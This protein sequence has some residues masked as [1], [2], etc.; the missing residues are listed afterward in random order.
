[1]YE[2]KR[3]KFITFEGCDGS[4]KS[5]QIEYF[6][7]YLTKRNIP[8]ITTREPGGGKISEAIR[9]II[10]DGKNAEMT[11]ECEALLYAAARA[12]H[13]KDTV[14][15]ALA[16]GKIVLCD[17]YYDS[18]FAYQAVARGLGEEF[19]EKINAFALTSYRPDA[20]VFINL[21]ARDAF[22]RKHGA[23]ENDRLEQAGQAFHDKVYEGFLMQAK[24]EPDRF[25]VVDGKQSK[26]EIFLSA[27]TLLKE[28]WVL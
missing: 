17:R 9:S 24:K 15:P 2:T 19:I 6:K 3:G 26:D 14:E 10:L 1:M 28:R 4:G 22:Q 16:Q 5:T 23:D 21:S 12:Q 20:T 27:L 25:V 18:S 11:D 13:L 7:D 8:F